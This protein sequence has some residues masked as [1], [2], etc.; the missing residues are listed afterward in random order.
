LQAVLDLVWCVKGV[1]WM[2]AWSLFLKHIPL[3]REL[4]GLDVVEV[5]PAV[6]RRT[7]RRRP[8][9]RKGSPASPLQQ[10]VSSEIPIPRQADV[11]QVVEDYISS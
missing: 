7:T 11:L 6:D 10:S 4:A 9:R 2:L 3:V 1:G 5:Q 8:R